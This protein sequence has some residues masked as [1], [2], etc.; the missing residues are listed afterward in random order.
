MPETGRSV[1][2]RQGHFL[3]DEAL[4]SFEVTES[5]D[6]LAIVIS[7]DCDIVQTPSVEPNVEIVV[8][9]AIET[10]DGNFTYSKNPRKLHLEC[11]AGT[12]RFLV[13]LVATDKM[14]VPKEGDTGL[15]KHAPR[16]DVRLSGGE[17]VILQQWLAARYRRSAFPDEFDHRLT[18]TGVRDQLLRILKRHGAHIL[19]IYFDVDDGEDVA[20]NGP[21]DPY[22]LTI[23]LLYSTEATPDEAEHAAME[24]SKSVRSVF[25]KK[26]CLDGTHW[27]WI[28]LADCEVLADTAM[29]VAQAG[30]LRKWQTDYISFRSEPPQEMLGE[31]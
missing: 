4:R 24:V 11:T 2:W 16:E 19:A 27:K 1:P 17:L 18:A 12:Q 20:H 5:A 6:K 30:Y 22:K 15:L 14:A 9:R 26:C 29:T 21:D 7:H 25:K 23:S 31:V 3:P 10:P 8:G 28:E 13:E